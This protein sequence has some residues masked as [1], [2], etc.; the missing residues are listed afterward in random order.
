[1]SKNFIVSNDDCILN[2][3]PFLFSLIDSLTVLSKRVPE[4]KVFA[5]SLP[6]S[7]YE[8][9]AGLPLYVFVRIIYNKYFGKPNFEAGDGYKWEGIMVNGQPIGGLKLIYDRL[10]VKVPDDEPYLLIVGIN[11]SLPA[12]AR[13]NN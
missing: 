2:D 9:T 5:D 6:V 7:E 3:I 10:N 1:M 11:A 12:I 4:S 8:T 13:F